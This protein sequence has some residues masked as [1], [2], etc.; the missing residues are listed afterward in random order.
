MKLNL[1]WQMSTNGE[2]NSLFTIVGYVI[3][4]SGIGPRASRQEVFVCTTNQPPSPL[5]T[6]LHEWSSA[7]SFRRWI[8]TLASELFTPHPRTQLVPQRLN[9]QLRENNI[10][11]QKHNDSKKQL[12]RWNKNRNPKIDSSPKVI[13]SFN[14]VTGGRNENRF[15]KFWL[16][17]STWVP[18]RARSGLGSGSTTRAQKF[19]ANSKKIF[20]P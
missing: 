4:L 1:T 19:G 2:S 13:H 14:R 18:F 9:L 5:S 17:L 6:K 3:V 20:L 11:E 10:T 7:S 16:L 15:K 12:Q 8:I